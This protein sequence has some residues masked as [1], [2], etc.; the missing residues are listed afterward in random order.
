MEKLPQRPVRHRHT[1]AGKHLCKPM[2]R[3]RIGA[4]GHHRVRTQARPV[5]ATVDDLGRWRRSHDMLTAPARQHVAHMHAVLEV[6]GDVFPLFTRLGRQGPF[7]LAT[8]LGAR[9]VL[10]RHGM[11]DP[12]LGQRLQRLGVF[13]ALLPGL[14]RVRGRRQLGR[15]RL[16][17]GL[18]AKDH[19]LELGDARLQRQRPVPPLTLVLVRLD[20]GDVRSHFGALVD[21]FSAAICK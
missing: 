8:A 2:K 20:H 9:A 6:P 15:D 3:Q 17:L 16:L 12:H 1:R 13:L 14:L 10:V 7:R 4:L 5:L 18:L 11:L 19:A 21:L